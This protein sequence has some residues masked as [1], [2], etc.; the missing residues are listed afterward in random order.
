MSHLRS[1]SETKL[2]LNLKIG[3][4]EDEYSRLMNM[5]EL[6]MSESI[7]KEVEHIIKSVIYGVNSIG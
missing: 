3:L 1:A 6:N 7:D 5:V 4:N 2:M